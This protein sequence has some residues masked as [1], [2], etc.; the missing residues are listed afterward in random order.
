MFLLETDPETT[1][2]NNIVSNNNV[3][4]FGSFVP[5]YKI[6]TYIFL[7]LVFCYFYY[8]SHVM[9]LACSLWR[10]LY[11]FSVSCLSWLHNNITTTASAAKLHTKMRNNVTTRSLLL[12]SC[13]LSLAKDGWQLRWRMFTKG[14]L[15]FFSFHLLFVALLNDVIKYYICHT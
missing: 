2:L 11:F 12:F 13:E 10:F 4:G 6:N 15:T 14:L 3:I 9:S 1:Y 8:E 7:I 5:L